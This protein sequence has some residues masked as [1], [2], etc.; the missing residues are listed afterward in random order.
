MKCGSLCCFGPCCYKLTAVAALGTSTACLIA[1]ILENVPVALG[2]G[3]VTAGL[4]FCTVWGFGKRAS[5]EERATNN[6]ETAALAV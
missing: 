2:T 1:T 4:M 3:G 6:D 5:A